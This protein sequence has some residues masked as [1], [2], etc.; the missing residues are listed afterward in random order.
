LPHNATFT[1]EHLE[2]LVLALID[3]FMMGNDA[4]CSSS[5]EQL[6]RPMME[7]RIQQILAELLLIWLKATPNL[8]LRT[9]PKLTATL[10]SWS[11]FGLGISYARHDRETIDHTA[12]GPAIHSAVK[13]LLHGAMR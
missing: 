6:V 5:R 8:A 11:I 12:I 3:F 4:N 7:S 2:M 10:V 13:L 1:A 9:T